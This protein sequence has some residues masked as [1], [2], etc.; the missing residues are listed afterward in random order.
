MLS[1]SCFVALFV[2]VVAVPLAGAEEPTA[3]VVK[4]HG[5]SEAI[6][7]GLGKTRAVL[8]PQAGGRVLEFST[9]GVDAMY[10]DE[11]EK[12][13]QPG[14]TIPITAGR[15]DYGPELTVRPHPKAWAGEWKAEVT[16]SNGAKLTSPP[17]DAGIQVVREFK[18]ITHNRFVGLSCSQ[19]LTNTSKEVREVCHWGRSFSPGGGICVVPLGDRPSRFPSKYAMYEDG[20]VINVRTKDDNIRERDGCLEILAPPRKPKLGFD[21]YAGWLA[22]AMPNDTLFVKRFKTFPDR[23]Y[24]E[25]AGLTLSVWYPTGPRIELEPIGPRERLKPGESASFTEEW[26][27]LPHPF[28]KTGQQLDLKALAEQVAKQTATPN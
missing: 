16:R 22:Y 6:E 21:S 19:T 28:P 8:C 27:V 7:L 10:F 1:R 18:L 13:W 17:E 24:N 15:F 2:L 25:A 23:V 5:Y 12:G 26:W 11:A 9:G 4:S 14:R 20:A 3:K